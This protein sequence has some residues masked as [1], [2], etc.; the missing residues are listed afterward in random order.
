[1]A[2]SHEKGLETLR[3]CYTHLEDGG[4]LLLNIQPGYTSP[5]SW[6][7]WLREKRQALPQPWPKDG[8]H[9]IASDGSEH[10]IRFRLLHVDPLEQHFTRQVRLEKWQSGCSLTHFASMLSIVL[11]IDLSVI[12]ICSLPRWGIRILDILI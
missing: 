11:I 10:I 2:G 1:M 8:H 7:L 3:N 5:E 6:K 9:N 12:G 4:A